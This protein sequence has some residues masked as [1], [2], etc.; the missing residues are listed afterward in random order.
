MS[1]PPGLYNIQSVTVAV[2]DRLKQDKDNVLL[3]ESLAELYD[4]RRYERP[5]LLC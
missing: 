4:D 3:M 5:F 1:F 2:E